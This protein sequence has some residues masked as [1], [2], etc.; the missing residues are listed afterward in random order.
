MK[1]VVIGGTG[2]FGSRLVLLLARDGHEVVVAGRRA[3]AVMALADEVGAQPLTL[4]RT[5]DLTALWA[6]GPEV[7]VDAAG[8]FH[9]YGDTP[10]L[11]AEACI[12]AGVHYIDLADN[13]RFCAG[14]HVLDEAAQA[15]GVCVLSGVS[16]VPALSSAAVT[17]LGKDADEIDTISS[18]ILP[19][20]RAPRGRSVVQS[21]LAQC[22]QPMC[23]PV[24]GT[25]MTQRS[26]SQP[27]SFD[28]GQGIRRKGWV[29]EVPD[30]GL[31]ASAFC[32]R[33]VAFRAGL[34]LGVMNHALAAFSWLRGRL[35]LGAPEW[36]AGLVL[37]LSKRLWRFGTD[38][39]GMCVAVTVRKGEQWERRTWRMIAR[40]GDGPFIP[41]V[42]ARAVLR[43]LDDVAPGARPAVGVVSLTQMEE[44][45]ADLAVKTEVVV[46]DIVPLFPDF[47]G[48]D[49]VKLPNS[50]RDLHDVPAPR[51]WAGRAKVTRGGS[52]WARFIAAVFGF[53]PARDDTPVT[54]TMT[55][56]NGGELWERQFDDK[57]FWSFLKVSEGRMTE[58][59]G[60]LTFT[61]GLHVADGQ[62]H[63]PVTS[64]RLGP[65]SFPKALLP[66]SIAREYE[67][68]GR[69]HF[70]VAL[71]A[72]LTGALMVHYQGWLTRD[73]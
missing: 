6:L 30:Q 60:L 59:F 5:G 25:M 55:P 11:L 28:L 38:V 34:E 45:M 10:F 19:G 31:F 18:A 40:A 54:V 63:F 56:R 26:W 57:H 13:L 17:A 66:I 49:Y 29:I 46:E 42:P 7:V 21:I 65:I 12:Q 1:V 44:G 62:L 51:R 16:S 3:T 52:L 33:T 8:P 4:D 39:G 68:D 41:A 58:R 47:L 35:G 43:A 27:D 9:A 23:A 71:K 73:E 36:L 24:D 69:F 2:V 53:P 37:W 50:L 72:P 64:G 61:L 32:A 70:D 22:G 15:A 20:N 48:A 14:I 67:A